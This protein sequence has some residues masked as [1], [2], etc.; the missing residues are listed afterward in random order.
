LL[1]AVENKKIELLNKGKKS[2]LTSLEE[3]QL[4]YFRKRGSIYLFAS[5]VASCLET[6]IDK[7][8]PNKFRLSFGEK[9][10]PIKSQEF[11]QKIIDINIPF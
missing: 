9:V 3:N 2:T 4:N 7:K 11:W 5:A 1:R 6:Y 8:I 10:S